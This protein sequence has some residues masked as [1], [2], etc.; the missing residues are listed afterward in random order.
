M[1]RNL[2]ICCVFILIAAIGKSQPYKYTYYLNEN[3]TSTEKSKA[4]IKGKGFQ[5]DSLFRLDCFTLTGTRPY[6]TFHFKD[7]S[8]SDLRGPFV[9]YHP[10]G[11]IYSQGSYFNAYEEGLWQRWDSLGRKID[12]SIYKEGVIVVS[13]ISSY[14]DNNLLSFYAVSDSLNDTCQ[15]ISYDSTSKKI[16]DAYFKGSRGILNVYNADGSKTMDSVFSRELTSAEF[17]GGSAGWTKYLRNNLNAN[18]PVDNN[19]P[20]GTYTVIIKFTVKKDGSI[21][22]LLQETNHRYGME[23]EVMRIIKKGPNWLP[24][25]Q[26]GQ[27]VDCIK[28]QPATFVVSVQ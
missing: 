7:S 8:L 6:M 15:S 4:S 24:A 21:V 12:S 28:R 22:D 10:N 17:P 20:P 3:I 14:H 11:K 2:I 13:G 5:E 23:Q 27:K 16:F 25:V 26:F 9:S 19:A 1:K 18:T